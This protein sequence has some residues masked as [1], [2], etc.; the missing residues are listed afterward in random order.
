MPYKESVHAVLETP[1]FLRDVAESVV[2]E[3]QRQLI[4]R[5]VA[6]NPR[7]GDVIPGTGGARKVRFAGRGKGK[8]GGY[9]V[10]TYFAADDVPVLLLAL[11]NKGQRADLSQAER[12]ALRMELQG[13]AE[14]YRAGV[15]AKISA[16]RKGRRR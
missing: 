9:R 13:F 8:S 14:D 6:E 2:S 10:V 4:V 7:Q 11:I 15:K 16:L 3:D 5:R 1:T 12:N